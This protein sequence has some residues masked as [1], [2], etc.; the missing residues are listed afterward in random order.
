MPS[1]QLV[2]AADVLR[3]RAELRR[4]GSIA[5]LRELEQQ[6]P[7]LA[8]PLMEELTEL[9]HRLLDHGLS[10]RTVRLLTRR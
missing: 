10:E 1:D 3:A 7:D 2:T 8:E 4:R 6:E 9:H 5:L